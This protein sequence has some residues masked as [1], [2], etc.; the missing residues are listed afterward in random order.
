MRTLLSLAVGAGIA[1]MAPAAALAQCDGNLYEGHFDGHT[2]H[3]SAPGTFSVGEGADYFGSQQ[4]IAL[5][6]A[7]RLR[8]DVAR[9]GAELG[10]PNRTGQGEQLVSQWV[11]ENPLGI[12]RMS[13]TSVLCRFAAGCSM[14]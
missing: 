8:E 2:A 7:E 10:G 3:A 14:I 12:E 1:V 4:A 13:R 5:G 11:A 6:A 9:I